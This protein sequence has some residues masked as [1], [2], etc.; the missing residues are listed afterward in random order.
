MPAYF[1]A[2]QKDYIFWLNFMAQAFNGDTLSL[3]EGTDEPDAEPGRVVVWSADEAGFPLKA[4]HSDGTIVDLEG[5]GDGASFDQ[6]TAVLA[7]Q[8]FS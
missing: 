8:V 3:A 1:Y 7:A 4:K 2:G 5:G 6:G